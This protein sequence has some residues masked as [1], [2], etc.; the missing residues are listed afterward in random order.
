MEEDVP[1]TLPL[2]TKVTPPVV[3]VTAELLN[4]QRVNCA[5]SR[6]MLQI[7]PYK[8]FRT[9]LVEVGHI[10]WGCILWMRNTLS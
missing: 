8:H 6:T 1:S 5:P 10:M 4:N 3:N 2:T 7:R 9:K